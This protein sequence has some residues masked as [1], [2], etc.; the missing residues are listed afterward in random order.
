MMEIL[1]YL[2][3]LLIGVVL[4]LM[5]GGGSI[6]AVP[7]LVYLLG[8][9][10]VLSTAY[11]LFIVGITAS[12]GAANNLRKGLVCLKTATVFAIPSFIAVYLT[13]RFLVPAMPEVLI[14]SGGILLTREVAL[15]VFFA[16]IM[17]L[18]A[19]SM[20]RKRKTVSEEDETW[21]AQFNYFYVVLEGGIVGVLTGIVGAGGGFLIIPALVIL[22]GLP[23]KLAVGTSLIIVAVKSLIG[24]VGDI[25][26]GQAIDWG[27][28]M[29]FTGLT[30]L[31]VLLGGYLSNFISGAKLKKGFG[32]FV[33]AMA[34]FIVLKELVFK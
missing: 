34:V 21:E 6:L 30:I 10:P 16:A 9:N 11:S 18:A 32:W 17:L 14:D 27:F 15:M 25:Q 12:V 2:G 33:L 28:L 29:G 4:G 23:M 3:A 31:G 5:G 8:V 13:R 24:F 1:G 19:Y 7:I 26:A 22:V 20:I